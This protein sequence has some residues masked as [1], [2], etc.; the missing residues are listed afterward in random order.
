[1]TSS[2]FISFL[3]WVNG[4]L[5]VQQAKNGLYTLE[6]EQLT[7]VSNQPPFTETNVS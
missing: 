5:Y 1:M 4:K 2:Y 7:L 3:G 6:H